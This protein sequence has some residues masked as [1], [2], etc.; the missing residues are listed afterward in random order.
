MGTPFAATGMSIDTRTLRPGDLFVALA[1]ENGDGHDHVAAALAAGAA[2]ALVHRWMPGSTLLV[3]DTLAALWALGRFARTRFTGRMVAVTGSVGKTTTKEMLRTILSAAGP[4]H[5]AVASYNNHWGVPLTLARMPPDVTFAVCEIG[6]NHPGEIA[7]LARMVRPHVNV[8]TAVAAAHIGFFGS[9]EAIAN[10]KASIAAGLEPGGI[11]VLPA[12]S[13]M[14]SR[15]VQ[16]SETAGAH[17]KLF[18]AN[19]VQSSASDADGTNADAMIGGVPMQ[20]R[21]NAPGAHMLSNALAALTAAQA[22]GV[23]GSATIADFRPGAGRGARRV[24]AAGMT[25]LD[26]SYNANGASVRAALAVL[27]KL[28][29]RRVA[30]L[31]DMRELGKHGAAEHASLADAVTVSADI[32]FACGPLMAHLFDAVPPALRGAYAEDSATLAPIVAASVAAGDA[33]LVKGSL[34]THMAPIV[35]ALETSHLKK[36]A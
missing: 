1:G 24:T 13:S 31:G 5:A 4:T 29:G 32:L 16:A 9:L 19:Q 35:R 25:L 11:S 10:E 26:E 34:G 7:P 14:L 6:T 2:G 23:D 27:A 17:T 36:P 3:E 12:E 33:V 15:L 8:V 20:F 28:P 30:V 21:V 22:L 18:G